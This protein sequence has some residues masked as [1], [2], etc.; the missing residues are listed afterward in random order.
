MKALG[1]GEFVL[2]FLIACTFA[3]CSQ[4]KAEVRREFSLGT[5]GTL[6]ATI[7]SHRR[8]RELRQFNPDQ[9]LKLK[10]SLIYAERDIQ[11]LLV[12]DPQGRKVWQSIFTSNTDS[13]SRRSSDVLSPGWDIR[14]Q[15]DWSGRFGDIHDTRS[16]FCGDDLLYRVHRTWPDDRSRVL[17]EVSGPSG[18]LLFTNT[19][20][21]K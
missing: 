7:D 18:V 6:I 5:N 10:V 15:G 17:Y 12:F 14:M 2:A 1:S 4:P 3:G 20:K 11:Q 8:V 9:S 21:E 19:Y 13:G 16:W